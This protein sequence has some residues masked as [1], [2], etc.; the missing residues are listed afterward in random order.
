[1][2]ASATGG[3]GISGATLSALGALVAAFAA[4]VVGLLNYRTQA[5]QLAVAREGQLTERF[6][7]RR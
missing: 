1:M 6:T 3:S 7:S 2:L 4:F 5:R